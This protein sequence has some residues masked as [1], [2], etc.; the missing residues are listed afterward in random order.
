MK[1]IVVGALACFLIFAVSG[2]AAADVSAGRS[3]LFNGGEP[4][5]TGLLQAN[6]LFEAAVQAVPTDPDANF[7]WALTRVPALLDNSEG[8][9]PGLPIDNA[10]ELLDGLGVASSGRDIFNWTAFLG[11]DAFGDVQ[12]PAGGPT[13]AAIQGF[14]ASVV[15]PE[16]QA[17][18]ANLSV[19]DQS[20]NTILTTAETG[21]DHD[22]EVDYG[23]VLLFESM[24]HTASTALR[25]LLSY[26]LDADL[27]NVLA[28]LK[29]GITTI[30]GDLMAVYPNLLN[31]LDSGRGDMQAAKATFVQAIDS[32]LAASEFIR[33]ESD[34]D[35][36]D[37]LITIDP[38]ELDDEA[39]FRTWLAEAKN[40]LVTGQPGTFVSK[41]GFRTDR[42]D[43]NRFFGTESIDPLGLRS[44]MPV[45]DAS[46]R[47]VAGTFPDTT[48]G[49]IFPDATT[50]LLLAGITGMPLVF[51]FFTTTI[52][53]DGS[54]A[55]WQSVPTILPEYFEMNSSNTHI[56]YAKLAR[57]KDYL[58]WMIK[59]TEPNALLNEFWHK[60][61][62]QPTVLEVAG[63]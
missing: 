37:D 45:Y 59:L 12:I 60:F 15:L 62:R 9:T 23:D 38:D 56:E 21:L 8:Y 30:N 50:E 33:S 55:D 16:I 58:Y 27:Y 61:F 57:D 36:V 53:I 6:A 13:G 48:M 42:M 26:D 52:T 51:P 3:L 35:L 7:F 46:G 47:I 32:Y 2:T 20:F 43:L 5:M 22:V 10:K 49:G 17:A 19:I 29:E 39:H 31:L 54:E 14:I 4:T 28:R 25:V 40:S 11:E 24:L 41:D 63:H 44:V 1:R 18:L 34:G